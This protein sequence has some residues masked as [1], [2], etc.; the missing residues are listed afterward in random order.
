MLLKDL[1]LTAGID[2]GNLG[3]VLCQC[4]P[5]L[6]HKL[7]DDAVVRVARHKDLLVVGHWPYGADVE[8][9]VR[10]AAALDSSPIE[11]PSHHTVAVYNTQ[12]GKYINLLLAKKV[13]LVAVLKEAVEPAL[14][15]AGVR[16]APKN[17]GVDQVVL[18]TLEGVVIEDDGISRALIFLV[19]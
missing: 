5:R 3:K 8:P 9:V 10:N 16:F 12:W 11:P 19:P 4:V 2:V 17:G 13:Q 15:D 14:K 7:H 1:A 6:V 18:G